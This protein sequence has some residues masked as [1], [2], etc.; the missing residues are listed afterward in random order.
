MLR[1]R[2]IVS[3]ALG[4]SCMALLPRQAQPAPPA[5]STVPTPVPTA[6]KVTTTAPSRPVPLM[7]PTAAAPTAAAPVAAPPASVAAPVSPVE[8]ARQGVVVLQRQGKALA[9]G[10]VLEADG[11]VLT[12]L[13]PLT[14]GNF[15]SVRYVDG[16]V[17]P[18]KIVHSDRAWDL[19]LLTPMPA[20]GV[21]TRT[22]GLRAARTPSFVGLQTFTL[23]PPTTVAAAPQALKL[24]PGLL[25]GDAASLVGA[26]ELGT[27]P[28]FVGGPVVNA[29]GEVVALVARA[30]PAPSTATCVPA[31]YGAP[32]TALKQFLQRVP[33]EATWLGVDAATEDAGAVRGVRVVSVVPNGP[34]SVAG[35]RPGRDAAE[36]DVIVAVDGSPVATPGALNEA[37]RARTATDQVEL[38]LF[39]M[40]RYRS[41]SVKPRPAPQLTVPPNFTPKPAPAPT[42]NPYR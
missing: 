19:A 12:A 15:L 27:K 14:N 33:A 36:A 34:A 20:P 1:L 28:A 40:G 41:V 22:V 9:L 32:V 26:Y 18:I 7:P 42:P 25:G 39:A 21:T 8:R 3:V 16:T 31:P 10:V 17:V 11:R 23:A 13:S 24:S 35:L 4:I 2:S 29:E 6:N 37:V 30:C 5:A 38:L